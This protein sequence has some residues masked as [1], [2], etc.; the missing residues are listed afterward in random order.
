MTSNPE[1]ARTDAQKARSLGERHD[2]PYAVA[3]ARTVLALVHAGRDELD[4]AVEHAQ[5]VLEAA[6]RQGWRHNPWTAGAL[7]VLATADVLGGR[8]EHALADVARA[9]AT[10]AL[11]HLEHHDALEVLRATAE[12]DTGRQLDGWHRIRP[13]PTHDVRD[14]RAALH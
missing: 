1:R 6:G 3:Q 14:P 11:H 8:P 5:A 10:T 7:V 13:Q 2:W 12:Y 4:A 9:E